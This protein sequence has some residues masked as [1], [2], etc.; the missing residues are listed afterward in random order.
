MIQDLLPQRSKTKGEVIQD[1]TDIWAIQ[2][3]WVDLPSRVATV[4]LLEKLEQLKLASVG[5]TLNFGL[6]LHDS[7]SGK[8]V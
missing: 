4:L 8:S 7:S 3:S 5:S 6:C 2:G 1:K